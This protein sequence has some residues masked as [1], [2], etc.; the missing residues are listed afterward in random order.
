VS[1][2]IISN[3]EKKLILF[4]VGPY[5]LNILKIYQT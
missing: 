4:K 1:P 3:M 2:T 5:S